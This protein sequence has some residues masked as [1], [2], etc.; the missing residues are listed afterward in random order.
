MIIGADAG[1]ANLFDGVIDEMIVVSDDLWGGEFVPEDQP[2][3]V[4]IGYQESSLYVVEANTAGSG[5]PNMLTAAEKGKVLTNEDATAKNYHTLHSA[6]AGEGP[7]HFVVQDSD[8]IRI[9]AN[10]GDTI[11]FGDTVTVT[12]GYAESTEIGATVTLFPI[13][14]TEW[15]ALSFHGTWTLETS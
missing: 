1:G 12:A 9:V 6:S 13:N 11:R 15:V 10:D 5:S 2:Y 14:D 8:G 7:L 4:E 3:Y